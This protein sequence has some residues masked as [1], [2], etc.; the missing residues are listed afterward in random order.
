MKELW[1]LF[2]SFFHIGTFTFGGGY[3]M[4]PLLEKE[5]VDNRG[6]VT[7][8]EL[9]DCYAIGQCTPGIIAVNTATFIGYKQRGLWGGI[10]ATLGMVSPSLIIITIIA[11]FF[12]KF[13]EYE[14]IQ[15]AFGGIRIV[16][17]ALI[18]QAVINM[19]NQSIKN[20]LGIILFLISFI[21]T[22]FTPISPVFVII[23]SAITGLATRNTKGAN[24]E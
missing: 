15:H 17:V 12:Q 10:W 19:W 21:L 9:L 2:I 8:D 13:Q 7:K 22:T 11:T 18:V 3:A 6:W 20:W 1:N 5:I 23:F 24:M 4:L 16:V 14:L